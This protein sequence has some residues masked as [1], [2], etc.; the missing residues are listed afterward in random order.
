MGHSAGLAFAQWP[1]AYN[2]LMCCRS[3]PRIWLSVVGPCTDSDSVLWATAQTQLL[4]IGSHVYPLHI[5]V[6]LDLHLPV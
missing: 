5:K 6:H 2:L 1:S 4:L 3:Q